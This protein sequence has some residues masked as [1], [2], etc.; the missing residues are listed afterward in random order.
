[1][2]QIL[3]S[4]CFGLGSNQIVDTIKKTKTLRNLEKWHKFIK[5][6]QI[7]LRFE[8]TIHWVLKTNWIPSAVW[9]GKL[10]KIEQMDGAYEGGLRKYF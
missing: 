5:K 1:M 7:L 9:I 2:Y 6:S 8:Y 10:T 4:L 3:T